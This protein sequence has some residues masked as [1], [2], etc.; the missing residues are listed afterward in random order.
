M[1]INDQILGADLDTGD[2]SDPLPRI[3]SEVQAKCGEVSFFTEADVFGVEAGVFLYLTPARARELAALV[4]REACTFEADLL[5]EAR[6]ASRHDER[7]CPKCIEE[8]QSR[9]VGT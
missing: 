5:R 7:T 2:D 6:A 8:R 9:S 1:K 4:V 3:G